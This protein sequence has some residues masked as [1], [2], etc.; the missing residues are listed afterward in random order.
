MDNIG[1][2]IRRI[3]ILL[4]IKQITMAKMLSLSVTSYGKIERNEVGI[5]P[6]RLEKIA[7]IFQ[8]DVDYIQNLSLFLKVLRQGF[9]SKE[10]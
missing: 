8:I 5:K 6:E 1:D 10:D 3:R 7:V 4:G 9:V 2:N